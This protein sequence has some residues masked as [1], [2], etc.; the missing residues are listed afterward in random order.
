MKLMFVGDVS[1]GEHFFSFGHGPRTRF[2]ENG[3]ALQFVAPKLNEADFVFANLEGPVSDANF[4]HSDPCARVFRGSPTALEHLTRANIRVVSV[5][6]NHTVQHGLSVFDETLR[7]LD[8]H[9]IKVIGL[10]GQSPLIL[11]SGGVKVAAIAASNVPDSYLGS[12]PC[13]YER[14]DVARMTSVIEGVKPDVDIVVV[15]LHWG[16]EGEMNSDDSQK[17]IAE[18]LR[19]AGADIVVGHHPHVVFEI[20]KDGGYVYAPSLGNFVF[21][22]P[23][24]ECLRQSGILEI[25]VSVPQEPRCLFHRLHL[26]VDGTPGPLNDTPADIRDGRFDAYGSGRRLRYEPLRKLMYFVRHLGRGDTGTKLRFLR[27]KL[28]ASISRIL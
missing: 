10:A 6:N 17:N 2:L 20:D 27:W 21:D 18:R 16:V 23:W 28:K 4:D 24:A 12:Q 8:S 19:A 5:A 11:E 25:D 1:P 15:C 22:L 13:P 9:D 14:L 3:N 7:L 26:A